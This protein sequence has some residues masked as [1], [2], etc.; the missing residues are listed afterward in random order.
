MEAYEKYIKAMRE[1]ATTHQQDLDRRGAIDFIA[2]QNFV[3]YVI[4][5]PNKTLSADVY[6]W[7]A[8]HG[9]VFN[10]NT[11]ADL[12]STLFATYD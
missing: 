2:G 4:P 5:E 3:A 9:K 7:G 6:S 11:V 1:I 12:R 10:A 8:H